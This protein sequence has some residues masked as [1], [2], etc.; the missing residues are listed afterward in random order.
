MY[1]YWRKNKDE[2]VYLSN[3][4]QNKCSANIPLTV[5]VFTYAFMTLYTLSLTK[6]VSEAMNKYPL[7]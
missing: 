7:D 5:S 2:D 3:Y 4:N 1:G 6:F